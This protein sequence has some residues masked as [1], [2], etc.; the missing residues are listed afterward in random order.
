M[1]RS[2]IAVTGVLL[3]ALLLGSC[4]SQVTKPE[5]YSGFLSD[6]SQL[7]ETTSATG[8]P[9]MRWVAPGF[10]PD[11]YRN[12]LVQSIRFYPTPSP[13][14]QVS[15]QALEDLQS[16]LSEQ[17][18]G[19]FARRFK[20]SDLSAAKR[21][22]VPAEQTLILRAAITGVSTRTKSLKPYEVL[23]IALVAAAA[24]T[25]AGKRDQTTELFV[26]AE[27]F[28]A[29]TG[30][31]VLQVVRKGFGKELENREEQVTLK[32]LKGV[33]DGMVRDIDRF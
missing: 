20:V 6:Y 3:S 10:K 27:L 13:S 22:A 26:E 11:N 16:Y 14:D 2:R 4:T 18:R 31:P 21:A 1:E 7:Q 28:D 32:T 29:S 33:V 12:V 23:P 8:Q 5:Q 15:A 24:M 25:A 17:V 30:K 19:A 9:V